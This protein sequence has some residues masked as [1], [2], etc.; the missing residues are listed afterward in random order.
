MD[1]ELRRWIGL[2]KVNGVD[3]W[4]SKI[5]G[6]MNFQVPVVL[7]IG[8]K[9]VP[10]FCMRREEPNSETTWSKKSWTLTLTDGWTG[11]RSYLL[12]S[13]CC[14]YGCCLYA[15]ESLLMC[16]YESDLP[17]DTETNR[18][19]S[20]CWLLSRCREMCVQWIYKY[21]SA[22]HIDPF[23]ESWSKAARHRRSYSVG[24][25][26]PQAGI[27]NLWEEV[28]SGRQQNKRTSSSHR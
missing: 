16:Y 24:C 25:L 4:I 28:W 17:K 9:S 6:F 26:R 13:W 10:H 19:F 3:W 1:L 20:V 12:P 11:G 21:I 27:I 18:S 5:I 22:G 14:S 7:W 23:V 8:I 2:S 15:L